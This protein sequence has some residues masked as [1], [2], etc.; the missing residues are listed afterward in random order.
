[1]F[2]R[3][4]ARVLGVDPGLSRCGYGVVEH[5]PDGPRAVAGGV[6]ATSPS[7]PITQRLLELA[8][9]LDLVMADHQPTA[10][11]VERV[12]F[13]A[14]VKTA[15]GVGQASGLALL[16]AARRG[17]EVTEYSPNE[18]KQSVAGYGGADKAQVQAMVKSLLGL[19]VAPE[20]PDVADALA[21]ALCHLTV[22]PM[23]AQI[24]AGDD[25]GPRVAGLDRAIRA[26]LTKEASR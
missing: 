10:V 8:D 2:V 1:M 21:L 17:L 24:A 12:L 6:I 15:M 14:N 5:T 26:A 18:V 19:D 22:A 25:D 3:E 7:S 16:A 11:A 13:Q 20:P 9:E 23:R 4:G